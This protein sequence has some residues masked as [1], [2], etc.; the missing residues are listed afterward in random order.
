[1]IGRFLTFNIT[2]DLSPPLSAHI[3]AV[4]T[5]SDQLYYKTFHA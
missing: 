5:H 1:M 4:S 2:N 3:I